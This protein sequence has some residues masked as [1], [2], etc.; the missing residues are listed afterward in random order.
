MDLWTWFM[1]VGVAGMAVAGVWWKRRAR[2]V[3]LIN[4][5]RVEVHPARVVEDRML[6]VVWRAAISMKNVSRRPRTLPVVAE[7]AT[8]SAG[9]KVYLASVYLDAAMEEINPG[10]V[11]LAWVEATLPADRMPAR[12]TL[13]GI[14][15][16]GGRLHLR[17]SALASTGRGV[18]QRRGERRRLTKQSKLVPV[19]WGSLSRGAG[20][21]RGTSNGAI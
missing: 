2:G 11:A 1:L 16:T 10:D 12:A 4:H 8:V 19:R 9:R 15:T 20:F 5:V 18:S 7:R 3:Y 6:E 21:V 14:G 13:A 17:F